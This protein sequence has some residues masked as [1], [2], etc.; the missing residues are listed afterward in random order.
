MFGIANQ[1]LAVIALTV[2][3]TWLV[4][5]GKARYAWVTLLPLCFV[6]TTTLTAAY[7][8]TVNNFLKLRSFQGYLD[9]GVSIALM[10]CTVAVLVS[11]ARRW[12]LVGGRRSD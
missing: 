1:L 8:S 3:T 12:I 2:A 7:L 11:S 10:F 6:A 4:N 9:A 5:S